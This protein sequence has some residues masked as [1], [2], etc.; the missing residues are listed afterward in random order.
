MS[1]VEVDRIMFARQQ[2]LQ[3]R[4]ARPG[5]QEHPPRRIPQRT[6]NGPAPLSAAQ[7]QLWYLHQLA[8]ESIAYNELVTIRKDGPFDHAAFAW[9][10]NE[11][12]R[13]HEAWRTTFAV[14]G[15]EP[16][17]IVRQHNNI[18]L[19]MVDLTHMP[20]SEAEATAAHKAAEIASAPYDLACGP[21][22]RPML[23]R[24]TAT[25]H[26]LY[27]AMHH[28]IFDGVSLYRIV[29]PELVALYNARYTGDAS[30]L[31]D[32]PIQYSDY[33][34][35]ERG[36]VDSPE[37]ERRLA[38][39]RARLAGIAPLDL[40]L[41][42]PRPVR[43]RFRGS[44]LPL[45]FDAATV[46]R[47]RTVAADHDATLFQI[48][49]A[50]YAY[51]LR[52]YT[53][54][55]DVV[56]ATAHDLRQAPELESMVG[57]C[58]TP[59]VLRVNVTESASCAGL[60]SQ[61]RTEVVDALAC[62]V[63]FERL[64]RGID[65]PRDQRRNP[66]FQTALVL[67]PP[68]VSP[69]PAWSIHQ[70]E[71]A[72][73]ELM[74]QSKFD[75]SVELDER[76]DGRID[77]RLIFSTDLFDTATAQ[78]MLTHFTQLV[79]N[80][81]NAPDVPLA[82]LSGPDN[83]DRRRQLETFN[84]PASAATAAHGRC[85]HELIIDQAARTPDAIAV[86]V[87]DQSLSYRE[88]LLR[89][90]RIAARLADAGAGRGTIV[91]VCVDRSTDLV[92]ALLAV[93]LT[94]GAYLPLDPQQP[95]SRSLFMIADAGA[96]ILLTDSTHRTL[97]VP[98][99]IATVQLARARYALDLAPLCISAQC[100]PSAVAYVIY[101]SGSTG[102][103]KGVEV[104][105]RNVVNL[106]TTL[107]A[108]LGMSD[109]DTCLSL[110]S[111]TFDI[112][113][114]DIF[115]ALGIGATVVQATGA[116][117]KDPRALGDLIERCAAT[118]MSATPTTWSMLIG[119]GWTGRPG[120]LA[121]S[122]G[123]PLPEHLA[124]ELRQRCR[125]VWNAT[126]PTET[127]VYTGGGFVEAGEP[128]T[129]GTP[130]PGVRI[131]IMDGRGHLLPCGVPGEIVIAGRGVSR[132]Y[133]NRPRETAA[134]FRRDPF[135]DGER[136]YRSGD[137][138]RLLADGRL[139]ILGRYD[140]QVKIR[141]FRVE[142]GEV[143][144]VLI[145][146]PQVNEVAV[147]V[148]GDDAGQQLVAYIVAD[149]GGL[150]GARLRRWA[151]SRLPAYMVP[152]VI[153]HLSALPRSASGKLDRAALPT[154]PAPAAPSRPR[155]P[156]SIR[157]SSTQHRLAELW[158]ELL[159]GAGADP[160]EDFF[161]LGGHSVLATR[162]LAEVERRFGVP[163]AVA[164]FLDHGTTLALLGRL[165]DDAGTTDRTRQ[166]TDLPHLF[167]VYPD[168]PSSMSLRYL[169]ERCGRENHLYPLITPPVRGRIGRPRT[170]GEVAE[171]LLRT[172][173]AAQPAGPYR[174][175]GYSFGGL[176]AYEL[177]RLLD[178][179]GD[180][181][182]WLGLLDTLTPAA[183]RALM[184]KWKSPSV[185][186]AR[187]RESRRS[188]LIADY[189]HNVGWATREKLIAAGLVKRRPGEQFD[190]RHAWQIM[191]A[192]IPQGHHVPMNLFV[193][194]DTINHTGSE[195]LGWADVHRGPLQIHRAPGDHDSLLSEMSAK[196]F[197]ALVWASLRNSLS[198]PQ[199]AL[200]QGS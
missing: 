188:K 16:R 17:Q 128:I 50:V 41:D 110:A 166:G 73:G 86:I 5:P 51:W 154:P 69:D 133:V 63:P 109:A 121:L 20:F 84:P 21:F 149:A 181:V 18:D 177:A 71:T 169:S 179:E 30:S 98:D 28:L 198:E 134:R 19:P 160:R 79:R 12:I 131:Y 4:L 108:E 165:I 156:T 97:P 124:A 185:R 172:I 186:M 189:G 123:E 136:M 142:L 32:P 122:A 111:A 103:P 163:I 55:D 56:F 26:R 173:R 145:E 153:L 52:S 200:S 49:A 105:H 158:S 191:L 119:A 192:C 130:L 35:W 42:H 27:L 1:A 60:L 196:D 74:G 190:I 82:E 36:W 8:P 150:D 9:A 147:A 99:D 31:P 67:E 162:L 25:H 11:V 64:V 44:M 151:R 141:G 176:L 187:L 10:F 180:Q 144:S 91:A 183:V 22:L 2:L 195:S 83:E 90:Q 48:V 104:E 45:T 77:G 59:V 167:F 66:L 168:L 193:T 94:G 107:P 14:S 33:S 7:L 40:P 199:T 47:L 6:D 120:L 140:N 135:V 37:V 75:I 24:L 161:D 132:G 87:G 70:M 61:I 62:A 137:R 182:A 146:H 178:S 102:T 116:Q 129:V 148:C 143:E 197:T 157:E 54:Q 72:V 159:P 171:P 13:R 65:P 23:V 88:L 174:L 81:A 76:S 92:P 175:I 93:L 126:G 29:L 80:A 127:T 38:R 43:Q 46:Q 115:C 95:Q 58:L 155:P 15:D 152:S 68:V 106:M 117:S 89:S 114:G 3:A 125:A 85:V 112:S 100:D 101:T 184:R 96:T 78:L 118:M 57:F 113:V 194:T 34:V 53:E 39:C 164:D 170:V 139:Q 138:G